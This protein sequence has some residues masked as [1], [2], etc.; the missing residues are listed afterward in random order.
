MEINKNQDIM[1]ILEKF[2]NAFF[3]ELEVLKIAT[4]TKKVYKRMIDEFI[5]FVRCENSVDTLKI[6]DLNKYFILRF[7]ENTKFKNVSSSTLALYLKVIKRFFKF[8]SENN[9]SGIDLLYPIEKLSIKQEEKEIVTYTD[10][11]IDKIKTYLFNFLDK[12]KNYE[13]F[14]NAL[15]IAFIAFTGMRAQECLDIKIEDVE[16]FEDFVRIKIKGKGDK[17]RYVYLDEVFIEYIK[18]LFEL[19]DFKSEYLFAKR[20]K[21]KMSFNTL[22]HYNKNLLKK[23]NISTKKAGLHI[24]RHTFAS[25]L[26]EDNVNLETI[27]EILGHSSIA[28]TSKHYAKASEKAKKE[29]MLRRV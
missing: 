7:L 17:E 18:R 27:K 11:E 21:N 23:L 29:A 19:R 4:N 16:I 8:I 22:Y 5:E 12:S 2:K 28:V 10:I 9:I 15:C 26:V 24:Y 14:K 6:L 3:A 1:E 20:D 25:N 13:R